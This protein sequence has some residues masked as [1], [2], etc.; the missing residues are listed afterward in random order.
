[1]SL[2]RESVRARHD[3]TIE[4]LQAPHTLKE[5]ASAV[6]TSYH[7]ARN[8]V[9]ALIAEEIVRPYGELNSKGEHLFIAGRKRPMPMVLIGT[10]QHPIVNLA[11]GFPSTQGAGAKEGVHTILSVLMELMNI[12]GDEKPTNPKTLISYRAALAKAKIQVNNAIAVADAMLKADVLW[13]PVRI[14]SIA[15][16]ES[17]DIDAV[18]AA[19]SA[20]LDMEAERARTSNTTSLTGEAENKGEGNADVDEEREA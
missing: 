1:M 12:V 5:I 7:T 6:G 17:F 20:Y 4:F 15:G 9:I 18:S 14:H 16:D 13:D 10:K 2:T 3:K 8:D 11:T 19:Y